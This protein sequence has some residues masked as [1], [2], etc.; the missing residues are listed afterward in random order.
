[1]NKTILG[2]GL[3]LALASTGAVANGYGVTLGAASGSG[4]VSAS[5]VMSAGGGLAI[6]GNRGSA[7]QANGAT[8]SINSGSDYYNF[9][10]IS[11]ETRWDDE[12]VRTLSHG[13]SSNVSGVLTFGNAVGVAGGASG[14]LGGA[15]A[16]SRGSKCCY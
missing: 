10:V 12:S 14:A 2:L 16:L 8:H 1:M 9:G 13:E 7:F 11:G 3:A 6:A 4:T 15:F 5:G